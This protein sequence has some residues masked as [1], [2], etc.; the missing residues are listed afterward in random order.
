MPESAFETRFPTKLR[1]ADYV[2]RSDVV[3][4]IEEIRELSESEAASALQSFNNRS[5]ERFELHEKSKDAFA[6]VAS[7]ILRY[8]PKAVRPSVGDRYLSEW[9]DLIAEINRLRS[10][11]EY[12][13]DDRGEFVKF[14]IRILVAIATRVDTLRD[15]T[16]AA[17]SLKG[18][19]NRAQ[20]AFVST[21]VAE[22]GKINRG[23]LAKNERLL[24]NVLSEA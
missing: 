9:A 11:P 10:V 6:H 7:A 12:L 19:K 16:D 2:R 24:A 15:L 4:K 21:K 13:R 18:F 20:Y 5:D 8:M 23:I 14:K 17:Y 1:K 3:S 22:I